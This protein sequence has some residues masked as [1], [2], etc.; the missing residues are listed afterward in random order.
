MH[1][2]RGVLLAVSFRDRAI[3]KAYATPI[4]AHGCRSGVIALLASGVRASLVDFSN[5]TLASDPTSMDR[6]PTRIDFAH[7]ELSTLVIVSD[8]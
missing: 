6:Q 8:C 2:P 1:T 4:D 7:R 3:P 5:R